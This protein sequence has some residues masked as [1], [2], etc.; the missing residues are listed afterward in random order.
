MTDIA[1]LIASRGNPSGLRTAIGALDLLKCGHNAVRYVVAHDHD[2]AAT[3]EAIDRME[4][5]SIAVLRAPGPRAPSLG[6]AWNRAAAVASGMAAEVFVT[7]TDRTLCRTPHWDEEVVRT[8]YAKPD[9]VAWWDTPD[10][11]TLA[12]VPAG[13]YEA[14]GSLFSEYFPFWFDDT[15]LRELSAMVHG[16]PHNILGHCG[17]LLV[18]G[19]SG[20][21][22]RMRD[23]RFWMDFFILKRPERM[24]HAGEIREKLGLP[25]PDLRLVEM[26]MHENDAL[27]AANWFRWEQAL[28]DDAPMDESYMAALRHAQESM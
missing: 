20:R 11:L 6:A 25:A 26:W 27:W 1:V 19:K 4:G 7:V 5:E 18:R 8:L 23:L 12:I 2:D 24:A 9:Q 14:A 17:A 15:W 28:R 21:T 10:P 22:R 13:W 3:S 16:L